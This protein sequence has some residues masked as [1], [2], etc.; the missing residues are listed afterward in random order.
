MKNMK[1]IKLILP[2]ILTLGNTQKIHNSEYDNL[3]SNEKYIEFS[4]KNKKEFYENTLKEIF[5][6]SDSIKYMGDIDRWGIGDL[7]Q[8]PRETDSLKTGD[9]EDK[10]IRLFYESKKKGLDLKLCWGKLNS[11]HR[12]GH[13]WN[14]YEIGD[15][16]YIIETASRKGGKI[17]KKDT[18]DT[19]KSYIMGTLSQRNQNV[20]K[21]FEDYS[22]IKLT[23]KNPELYPNH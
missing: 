22:G 6:V 2:L 11:S 15:S 12:M 4:L 16:T 19:K 9:C 23:F 13:L 7:W 1:L 21:D 17:I 18:I 3:H 20:T 8:T 14:E 5:T 10:A